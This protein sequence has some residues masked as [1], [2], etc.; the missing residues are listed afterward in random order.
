MRAGPLVRHSLA[1]LGVLAVLAGVAGAQ[2][3]QGKSP[4]V[5]ALVPA[6]NWHETGSEKLGADAAATWGGDP[7]VESEFGV[8]SIEHRTYQLE[9]KPAGSVQCDV[10]IE[11]AADPS[12]AYGL[13]TYY[14]TES[15][16]H[17]A[18]TPLVQ[19]GPEGG[20]AVRGPVFLRF[21]A[22][23]AVRLSSNDVRALVILVA[24]L[25]TPSEATAGLPD[26]LLPP[27]G[28]VAGSDRYVLG[29]EVA[30]RL[31]PGFPVE[32]IGFAQG[33]EAQIGSYSAEPGPGA[34]AANA[35]RRST[36][37]AIS[38]PTFQIARERY[39]QL[40]KALS[41]NQERGAVSVYGK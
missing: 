34:K 23:A 12:A 29:T 7:A 39:G 40:E 9:N 11:E 30:R 16:A 3:G 2:A 27:A 19:T 6:A 28:L 18:A 13:L 37:V 10:L 17:D 38:Y 41:L 25:R 5:I 4:S 22:P 32:T 14:H 33:A 15:M 8:R 20:V 35:K 26:P 1:P 36:L 21:V 24:G 31:L